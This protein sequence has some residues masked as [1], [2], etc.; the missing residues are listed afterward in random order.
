MLKNRAH[1]PLILWQQCSSCFLSHCYGKA[2]KT[3]EDWVS[4]EERK[5]RKRRKSMIPVRG[6]GAMGVARSDRDRV[7]L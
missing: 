1:R 6:E 7:Y 3:H 4:S 5:K 2:A